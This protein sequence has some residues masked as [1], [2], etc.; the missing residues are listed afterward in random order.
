MQITRVPYA[1]TNR[2]SALINDYLE[3][4]ESLKPFFGRFPTLDSFESQMHEKS[5]NYRHR[6]DLV[7]ALTDQYAK[8]GSS[9]TLINRLANSNCYTVTT[10]HQLC[11]FTGPLYFVYKII[12][13]IKLAEELKQKYPDADFVPVFWMASE[14]H[15]FDEVNHAHLFGKK[16]VWESGQAGAV[17]RMQRTALD[18]TIGELGEILGS[19]ILARE[20]VTMI[21]EAYGT[22]AN[23]ALAT[24]KLVTKLFGKDRLLIIDGDDIE[25]KSLFIPQMQRELNEQLSFNATS[26]TGTKLGLH[27]PLQVTP[28]EINLFYLADQQRERIVFEDG[29]FKVLH[30]KLSFSPEEIESELKAHPENFSPNVILRPLYQETILPNLAYIGGGGELAYWFQLKEMFKSFD[31]TFPMLVLRNSVLWIGKNEAR[32]MQNLN[33]DVLALFG[34][35][36]EHTKQ[37]VLEQSDSEIS[38]NSEKIQLSTIFEAVAERAASIDSTLKAMVLAEEKRAL[39]SLDGVEK[40]MM[41]AEKEKHSQAINQ[42]TGVYDKL[43]P[44]GSLQERHNNFFEFYLKHGHSF[45]E[46]LFKNL[47]PL[48]FRFTILSD[49]V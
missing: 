42:L 27:Y 29:V 36:E 13:T 31:V 16:L 14:D 21:Q 24:R 5:A 1:Q 23:W 37:L 44:A 7:S 26:A 40:R 45:M 15:D 9:S 32:K 2:F 25:L 49:E 17:G 22:S 46:E 28:R 8:S 6:T 41:K 39:N 43:F 47:N 4:K 20:A 11:L 18:E 3:D 10:G 30:T 35:K 19:S 38:L 34:D 12:T 48:D 33:L